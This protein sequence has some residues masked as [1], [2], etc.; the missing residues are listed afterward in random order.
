MEMLMARKLDHSRADRIERVQRERETEPVRLAQNWL[1][2]EYGK[3]KGVTIPEAIIVD[4]GY[5]YWAHAKCKRR[6][7]N[8]VPRIQADIVCE[9]ASHIL[10]PR[11]NTEFVLYF[12]DAGRLNRITIESICRLYRPSQARL[13]HLNLKI[14]ADLFLRKD[15]DGVAIF[16][17]FVRRTFFRNSTSS[18]SR[19]TELFFENEKNFD[20]SCGANHVLPSISIR[21]S[22]PKISANIASE[23]RKEASARC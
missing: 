8:G 14:A 15:Y 5:I 22:V 12:A 7:F 2:M 13:R 6:N 3:I 17:D 11:R 23:V 10:P 4:P 16:N 19:R 21:K 9:R 18:F 20:I 1:T